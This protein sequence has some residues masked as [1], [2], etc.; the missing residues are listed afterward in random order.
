[1]SVA[2]EELE[3]AWAERK[4]SKD[5]L[6]KRTRNTSG[7]SAPVTVTHVTTDTSSG[8]AASDNEEQGEEVDDEELVV[9]VAGGMEDSLTNDGIDICATRV[10][11]EV[12]S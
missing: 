12:S 9:M 7:E 10:A 4:S 2:K 8:K 3:S 5:A 11:Y 1:M 6:R